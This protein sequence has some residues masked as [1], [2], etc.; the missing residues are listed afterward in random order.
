ML[1]S[2]NA[3]ADCRLIS[4]WRVGVGLTA[5][6]IYLA[7]P[8]K[9]YYWDGVSF[10]QTIESARQWTELLHP[11]HL[12][13]CLIGEAAYRALGSTVRA[14]YLL[15]IM[16]AVF[17]AATIYVVFGIIGAISKSKSATLLLTAL[18]AFSGT[19][20]RFATDADAYILSVFLITACAALLVPHQRAHPVSVAVLHTSAMLVHELAL[21]FFPAVLFALWHQEPQ[22]QRSRRITRVL[23]YIALT[24]TLTLGAYVAAFVAENGG[25]APVRFWAWTTSHAEDAA[26]S[27][28]LIQNV[29]ATARS[30]IQ[31]LLTG[32]AALV[33]YSQPTT[34]VL[35]ALL[36]STLVA[37]V[38]SVIGRRKYHGRIGVQNPVF[39]YFALLWF[40]AYFLF[41]FFWLPHNTFYKLFALPAGIFL[42]V[43]CWKP[44]NNPKGHSIST[45]LVATMA[46]SNLTFGIVPYSRITAN[47]AVNFAAH[48]DSAL[49]N[50]AVVYYWTFN[51]DDWFVRYFNPQSVWRHFDTTSTIDTDLS[52]GKVVWLDTT[53]IQHF[54]VEDPTWL[55]NR[56][57]GADRREEVSPRV[58]IRF[59]HLRS[60][61]TQ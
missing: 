51:T 14:L 6:L 5:L 39:F 24:G 11:N 36:A 7:L 57:A 13:Y 60:P 30:W 28:H 16:N 2:E 9:N 45:L 10:A 52:L 27:F 3:F 41:L 32:R 25:G 33:R 29:S 61:N 37:L 48:L 54:A 56:S 44:A 59:V 21:F 17:A 31:L 49:Q 46:L 35:I 55:T 8:T 23:S 26:F 15:Q 22:D 38:L 1:R 53:A 34:I 43:S 4:P 58:Y 19:W 50:G 42:I 12:V 47:P 40:G 18:F 20:W